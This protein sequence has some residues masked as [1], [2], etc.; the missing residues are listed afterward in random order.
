M[1][2]ANELAF[3]KENNATTV[4]ISNIMNYNEFDELTILFDKAKKFMIEMLL[5]VNEEVD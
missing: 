1:I 4:D 3:L 2:K 5:S